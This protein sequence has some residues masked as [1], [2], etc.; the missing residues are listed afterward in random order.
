MG[1]LMLRQAQSARAAA[2]GQ[3]IVTQ[4]EPE[5]PEWKLV[6]PKTGQFIEQSDAETSGSQVDQ[7]Q[8]KNMLHWGDDQSPPQLDYAIERGRGK[9]AI[10]LPTH[11]LIGLLLAMLGH[12]FWNGSLTFL[13]WALRGGSDM[14]V[15]VVQL[16][17]SLVLVM[18]ILLLGRGLLASVRSAPDGSS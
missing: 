18:G 10:P 8:V 14:V 17:W 16:C 13:E 7:E 12:A 11:P 2:A 5:L 1:W 15:I 6:D 4:D 9:S 3:E